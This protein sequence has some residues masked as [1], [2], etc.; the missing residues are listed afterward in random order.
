M[1][2]G[3]GITP[4][5]GIITLTGCSATDV[6]LTNAGAPVAEPTLVGDTAEVYTGVT[7]NGESFI[8]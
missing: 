6:A 4:E 7:V 8:K 1:L 3:R 2:V 5:G